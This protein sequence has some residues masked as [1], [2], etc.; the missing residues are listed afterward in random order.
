MH[1]RPRPLAIL[2]ALLLIVALVGVAYPLWWN[3][4][5]SQ[6]G[7]V[8]LGRALSPKPVHTKG[9][10]STCA[11]AS[12]IDVAT[13]LHPGILEIPAIG[14][15]APVLQG[16]SDAVFDVAVGH[17]PS[18]VW[19]GT[20]GESVL[21]AHDVS[22]F[23]GLPKVHIGDEVIWI[24]DCREDLFR[25]TGHEISK[26]G[27]AVELSPGKAGLLL[28]TCWP[29]DALFWTSDRF[30]VRAIFVGG[31]FVD[32]AQPKLSTPQLRLKIPAP[33]ALENEGLSLSDSGVFAGTLSLAGKPSRSFSESP[34]P[35]EAANS[36]LADYAAAQKTAAAQNSPWW[37][38]IA[39][40]GIELP[41]PWSLG[42]ETD[43]TLSI[44]GNTVKGATLSSATAVVTLVVHG[45]TLYVSGAALRN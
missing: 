11:N 12:V 3:H 21:L 14:L 45:S 5:S 17:E 1:T 8:L 10:I 31:Q 32:L 35:L 28:V 24:D 27:T 44:S 23:S 37:T 43:V 33:P 9:S 6:V 29:T 41:A 26:P 22:Y 18:T 25:V 7:R 2:G 16:A 38:A 40:P 13:T 42:Y 20:I 19:P 36:V 30:V 39:L 4:R 15:K 34:E